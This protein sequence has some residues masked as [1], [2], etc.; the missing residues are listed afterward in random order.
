VKLVEE[1]ITHRDIVYSSS[2]KRFVTAWRQNPKQ[3]RLYGAT[4]LLS[5]E[6]DGQDLIADSDTLGSMHVKL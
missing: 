6:C 3:D 5:S 1:W 2:G 4:N